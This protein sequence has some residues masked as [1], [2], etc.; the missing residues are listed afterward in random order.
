MLRKGFLGKLSDYIVESISK[1]TS[2]MDAELDFFGI[3]EARDFGEDRYKVMG[4]FSEWLVFDR[5]QKLFGGLT[6]LE[7]FIQQ[8]SSILSPEDLSAYKD[9]L[10]FEVG[11]FEVK[12]VTGGVGVLLE[13]IRTQDSYFVHDINSSLTLVQGSTVWA[14][15]AAVTGVYHAVGSSV[16]IT[17]FVVMPE[18][19]RVMS[20]WQKNSFDAKEA[21]A[22]V[23][24]SAT[25]SK[26]SYKVSV[27]Y[28]EAKEKFC[29]ALKKA[30][31]EQFF[32]VATFEKWASDDIKYPLGFATK[33]VFFLIPKNIPKKDATA[34]IDASMHFAN[35]IPKKSLKGKNSEEVFFDTKNKENKESHVFEM[36]MMSEEKYT[37]GLSHAHEHMAKEEFGTSYKAFE[38]VI[39]ELLTDKVPFV[40]VYRMYANAA[41]CQLHD[42]EGDMFLG[43]ELLDAALRVNPLYDFA[44]AMKEKYERVNNDTSHL[45]KSDKKLFLNIQTILQQQVARKYK[46]TV[47]YKY[48]QF[49]KKI[50]VSL[51]HGTRTLPT[52]YSGNQASVLKIG[53]NDPC[54]CGSGIKYKKCHG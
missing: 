47:F 6:G 20:K 31:M 40:D 7:Y 1:D 43:M 8:Q 13:S 39:Q 24:N 41:V 54:Y 4:L 35:A 11:L 21:S 17:P 48:E 53:R 52:V 12:D 51:R 25:S 29:Q 19:K 44:H 50:G 42:K 2:L 34:M 38:N 26:K 46:R 10:E 33:A 14:R 18:M 22:W 37:E 32:S 45:S 27:S 5:K 28:S 15:I 16:F 30:H 9:L 49:L 3:L 36:D 23:T